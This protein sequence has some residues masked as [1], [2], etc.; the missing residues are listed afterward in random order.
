[1]NLDTSVEY[2]PFVLRLI[3]TLAT[4]HSAVRRFLAYYLNECPFSFAPAISVLS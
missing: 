2:F 4:A 3:V 1:M